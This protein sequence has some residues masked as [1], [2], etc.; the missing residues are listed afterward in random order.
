MPVQVQKTQGQDPGSMRKAEV[1]AKNL[2]ISRNQVSNKLT[3]KS[4][5]SQ[6]DVKKWSGVLGIEKSEYGDYFYT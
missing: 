4:G 6:S 1:L 3:G 2:G 5:F